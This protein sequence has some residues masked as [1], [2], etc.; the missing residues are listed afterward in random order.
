MSLKSSYLYA[1]NSI[2][3]KKKER[4]AQTISLYNNFVSRFPESS[5]QKDAKNIYDNAQKLINK[6]NKNEQNN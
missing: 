1:L 3:Q 6:S 4:L 5:Y 2:E